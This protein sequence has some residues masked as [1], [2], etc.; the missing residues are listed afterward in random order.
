MTEK[1]KLALATTIVMFLILFSWKFFYSLGCF[2]L[3]FPI[4]VLAI[5]SSSFI[6][7]KM[8]ERICFKNCYFQDKSI[9]SKIL[10][11]SIGVVVFYFI[12]S[13]AFTFSIMYGAINFPYQI[14]LYLFLHVVLVIFIYKRIIKSLKDTIQ[15]KYINIFSREW[16]IKISSIF[17]FFIYGY[18]FYNGYQPDY[19]VTGLAQTVQNASNS[20][21]SNCLFIDYLFR[22]NT[23]LDGTFWWVVSNSAETFDNETLKTTIWASFI[24]INSLAV[25]GINRLIVQIVY[26]VDKIFSR[27]EIEA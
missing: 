25:L 1:I 3:L 13:I 18:I 9:F 12:L 6:D 20:I 4:L 5:V 17:L 23:E 27:K 14:W 15:D 26:L 24:F 19:L 22:L 2:S 8:N 21:S 7:I 10:T 16:T 11:S